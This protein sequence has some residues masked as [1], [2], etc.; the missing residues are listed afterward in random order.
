M[1]QHRHVLRG[2]QRH[3]AS[4]AGRANKSEHTHATARALATIAL[5][6]DEARTRKGS[7]G[8]VSPLYSTVSDQT[9]AHTRF[10][11]LP[12]PC[13]VARTHSTDEKREKMCR[14]MTAL[15]LALCACIDATRRAPAVIASAL[16]GACECACATPLIVSR[17]HA[18]PHVASATS[19][20]PRTPE[21]SEKKA[22]FSMCPFLLLPYAKMPYI[23]CVPNVLPRHIYT[24]HVSTPS[25]SRTSILSNCKLEPLL[26]E[27]KKTQVMHY[28]QRNNKRTT[29]LSPLESDNG[30]LGKKK[31]RTRLHHRAA[32]R[33]TA[34][35]LSQHTYALIRFRE[36]ERG[37]LVQHSVCV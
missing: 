26:Q 7:T 1:P 37:G 9:G 15:P 22:R 31:T 14:K 6:F 11:S 29:T 24:V 17:F 23:V 34:D 4:P 16:S 35:S 28:T 27:G 2:H 10:S 19:A 30:K 32:K 20:C 3:A 12:P 36:R 13:P 33:N 8:S 18:S 25:F 21:S 5:P